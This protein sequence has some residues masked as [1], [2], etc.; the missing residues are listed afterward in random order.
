MLKPIYFLEAEVRERQ[1]KLQPPPARKRSRRHLELN[2]PPG[3]AKRGWFT[4]WVA[5]RRALTGDAPRQ[6]AMSTCAC[7]P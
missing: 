5:L 7:Q 2:H 3:C 6:C 4:R 1:A